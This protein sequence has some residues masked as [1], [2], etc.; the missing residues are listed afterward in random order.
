MDFIRQQI[1]DS[2]LVI[3]K[4]FSDGRGYFVETFRQSLFEQLAG[5]FTFVQDNQSMSVEVGTVRGLHFQLPP[6]A[7]GKLVR[8]LAGAVLDVA[9]DIRR[10]SPTF[11]QHVKAELSAKNGHQLWVPPGFA[12]GFCTLQP[13]SVIAYKV[14]D[15]YSPQHDRGLR[16]NDPA[17]GI[18][19]PVS[20][21]KAMLSEKDKIQPLLSDLDTGFI[22]AG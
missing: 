10:G 12:H 19:W 13:D 20:S 14:T 8:C 11:G 5:H 3:P 4:I 1:N 15:Y 18:V 9:I 6:K 16:W 21:D 7:Q 2:I 17:L 22:Y